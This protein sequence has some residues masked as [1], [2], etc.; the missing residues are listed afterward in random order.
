MDLS[1]QNVSIYNIEKWCSK[2]KSN[3]YTYKYIEIFLADF[4]K[5]NV[6]DYCNN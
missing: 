1:T 3:F 4:F 6:E 5:I 2:L